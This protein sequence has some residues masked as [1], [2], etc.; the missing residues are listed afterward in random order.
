MRVCFDRQTFTIQ[1]YGGISRYFTDLYIGLNASEEIDADLLFSRHQN[2]YLNIHGIGKPIP[3]IIARYYIMLMTRSSIEIPLANHADIHHSTYYLGKPKKVPGKA[4]LTSTLYDMIPELHPQYFKKNTNSTKIKW[5]KASDLI[6]SISDSS[7]EDLTYFHP[8]LAKRIR[9]IHLYSNFTPSSPQRKPSTFDT[10]NGS[11][12]LYVGSRGG[13]KNTTMLLRAYASSKPGKHNHKLIFAGGSTLTKKEL[14][15]IYRL[16][17]SSYVQQID[18][19]DS[20]LWYLY[21]HSTAVVVPSMA[22]GFSLPLVEG[23]A[24]DVPVVCSDIP[25]HREIAGDYAEH[26]NAL[27]Y[28]DWADIIREANNLSCPSEKLGYTAYEKICRYY[29]R[30]R[31]IKEHIEAYK[32]ICVL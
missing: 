26:V 23:L 31:M 3:P 15:E 32:E 9:R 30:E 8:L 29:S 22:E 13:Y 12:I 11:Y 4:M 27:Q 16:K 24:A 7:T 18:V 10:R 2:E 17:I 14:T 28:R 1:R 25:V 20:E 19:N 5:L 21:C 6:I